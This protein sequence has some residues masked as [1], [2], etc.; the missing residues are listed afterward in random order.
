MI[1]YYRLLWPMYEFVSSTRNPYPLCIAVQV[2]ISYY[3]AIIHCLRLICGIGV[4]DLLP[5]VNH[6]AVQNDRIVNLAT[7]SCF[8]NKEN[9]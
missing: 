8:M 6:R 7:S 4:I 3:P 1:K 5:D 9:Q 2:N